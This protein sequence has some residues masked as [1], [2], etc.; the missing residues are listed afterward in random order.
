MNKVTLEQKVIHA[1]LT[2]REANEALND[3]KE[4][5]MLPEVADK[6]E[7]KYWMY[8]NRYGGDSDVWPIY[9]FCSKVN[10][11]N[12]GVFDSFESSPEGN[13]FNLGIKQSFH[14]CEQEIT[15]EQ[16]LKQAKAFIQKCNLLLYKP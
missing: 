2:L 9:S 11:P 5:L 13:K 7:G 4:N 10:R 14:L 1:R 6:Y 3:Y 8:L 12:E 15:K 16:Y